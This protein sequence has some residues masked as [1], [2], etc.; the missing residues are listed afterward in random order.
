MQRRGA[1]NTWLPFMS[2]YSLRGWSPAPPSWGTRRV[3][4]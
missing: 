1:S 3:A 4:W 2:S